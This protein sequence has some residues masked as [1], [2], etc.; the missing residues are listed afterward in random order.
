M[1]KILSALFFFAAVALGLH[2]QE[3][4]SPNGKFKMTFSLNARDVPCIR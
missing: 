1:K 3:L 2:A 4:A